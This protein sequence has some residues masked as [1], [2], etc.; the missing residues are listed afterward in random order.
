MNNN[1]K[2]VAGETD[3]QTAARLSLDVSFPMEQ[4]KILNTPLGQI[5]FSV[6]IESS[7]GSD[8]EIKLKVLGPDP[9]LPVGM[10]VRRV[11]AVLLSAFSRTG[12]NQLDFSFRFETDIRGGPESGEHLD[13]QSWEGMHDIIVVGTEDGEALSSRMPWLEFMEDPLALVQYR[14]DGLNIPLKQ[15]PA[16]ET[17][18]LHYIIA[19]NSNPE[20]VECSAWYAVD[21]PHKQLFRARS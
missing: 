20:P 5:K 13:A 4:S 15:I 3:A 18:G 9:N 8:Y 21:I 6:L 14:K 7:F 17:I 19:E 1:V 2:P 10:S 11:R 12:F 16:G